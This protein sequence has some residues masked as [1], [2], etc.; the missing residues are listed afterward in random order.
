M[1]HLNNTE[2]S[3]TGKEI[4]KIRKK[5]GMTQ[6]EFAN[7]A[8]VSYS[9]LQC[10]ER[11]KHNIN[12]DNIKRIEEACGNSNERFI[13]TKPGDRLIIEVKK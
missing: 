7:F 13:T 8:N 3:M 5:L 9:A 6:S 11:G 10:W 2:N 12:A 1:K 4:K